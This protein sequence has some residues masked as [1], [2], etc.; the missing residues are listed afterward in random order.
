MVANALTFCGRRPQRQ[1]KDLF[2]PRRM[3]IR[4]QVQKTAHINITL[5]G[6]VVGRNPCM[7]TAIKPLLKQGKVT[8]INYLAK[9]IKC[10]IIALRATQ[11]SLQD[12]LSFFSWNPREEQI[13]GSVNSKSLRPQLGESENGEQPRRFWRYFHV[14]TFAVSVNSIRCFVLKRCKA[15]LDARST[16]VFIIYLKQKLAESRRGEK[17]KWSRSKVIVMFPAALKLANWRS[18][19]SN[20]IFD[21]VKRH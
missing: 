7:D 13:S 2:F 15:A 8:Q 9:T 6:K 19:F 16:Y 14:G 12:I 5:E 1:W 18:E 11:I 4:Q 17:F 10:S 20:F 21:I 3:R